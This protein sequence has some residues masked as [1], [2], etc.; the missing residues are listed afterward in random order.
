MTRKKSSASGLFI[1]FFCVLIALLA[2]YYLIVLAVVAIALIAWIINKSS[3]SETKT[4][5]PDESE[6]IGPIRVTISSGPYFPDFIAKSTDGNQ[7]WIP[8]GESVRINGVDIG[9]MI[10][11]GQGLESVAGGRPEPALIDPEL[12]I[13]SETGDY[14]VR[15]LSYWPSYWG[16]SPEARAAYLNWLGSGRADPEADIGYVFL[17]FYG[18]ERRTLHEAKINTKALAEIPYL[19]EEGERL[20]RIYRDSGSFQSYAGS[21]V[22]LLTTQDGIG[23]L[24][25][26]SPPELLAR[27]GLSFKHKLGIAQCAAASNPLPAEWAYDWLMG[28][29]NTYLR[30]PASRCPEEF[31]K[32]FFHRYNSRYGSGMI[33][34]QNKTRLS[35]QHRTASPTF[36]YHSN[37]LRKDFD[38]PDVSILAGP[39]NELRKLGDQCCGELERYSRIVGKDSA[40]ANTFNAIAELPLVLWPDNYRQSLDQLYRAVLDNDGPYVITFGELVSYFPEW[41]ETN[42]QSILASCRILE[43]SHIGI[44][45]DLR[46]GGPAPLSDSTVALFTCEKKGTAPLQGK[47]YIAAAL[48]VRLAA[49]VMFADGDASEIE[50]NLLKRQVA[51]WP[52][53]IDPERT[54]LAAYLTL[55]LLTPP[56]LTG[57]KKQ[58]SELDAVGREAIANF[59][60]T[61][62]QADAVIDAKEMK[63]LEKIF[64]TL[65]LDQKLLYSKVHQAATE[66]ITVVHPASEIV[67]YEIPR[68]VAEGIKPSIML[69]AERVALLQEDSERV[70]QILGEIFA[71]EPCEPEEYVHPGEDSTSADG[72]GASLIG[73]NIEQSSFLKVLMTRTQWSRNELEEI[74]DDR[75][76]LLDGAIED[77]NEKAFALFNRAL[78]E[79]EDPI[80]LDHEVV[81][82]VQK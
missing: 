9:D 8:P 47:R 16:A 65:G 61:I 45:P 77:I 5:S 7:F 42:K 59:L 52:N 46:C 26:K 14:H 41:R 37:E 32:L 11:V 75:K 70:S 60:C 40:T 48:T 76:I 81:I 6:A 31:R 4:I 44:E 39:I 17:Y 82:E 79:G 49:S 33:L 2:K 28:D 80:V 64:S 53:L 24:F 55:L 71:Q 68:P 25:E 73:L 62:A 13:S 30:T 20:L 43:E 34:P 54:R 67:G 78:L 51:A 36:P 3:G 29:P 19:I 18:I 69:N 57:L 27:R 74:A 15:H 35:L 72:K 1:F 22:D 23:K 58:I 21:L 63:A 38:L 10:Y 12:Q 56:K 50:K 66:P